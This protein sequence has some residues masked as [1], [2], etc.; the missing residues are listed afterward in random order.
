MEYKIERLGVA[1][2]LDCQFEHKGRRY[3]AQVDKILGGGTGCTICPECGFDEL[4]T[5]DDVPL[6]EEGLISCIEEFVAELE[7]ERHV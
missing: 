1:G 7:E 3:S 5:K 4:Y 2:T 6:T